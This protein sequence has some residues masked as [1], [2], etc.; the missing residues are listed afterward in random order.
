MPLTGGSSRAGARMPTACTALLARVHC[1]PV[2]RRTGNGKPTCSAPHAHLK[3]SPI[4]A[5]TPGRSRGD[6]R[7]S[8]LVYL[9]LD[10]S[11]M[12]PHT[13]H[14]VS[15]KT[16]QFNS[17]TWLI[18]LDREEPSGRSSVSSSRRIRPLPVLSQNNRR[19][20]CFS[21]RGSYDE[22]CNQK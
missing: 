14:A 17:T 2:D 21:I 9:K 3:L 7:D 5:S 13:R 18:T 4:S 10:R 15:A 16:S 11:A 6:A 1:W 20:G 8:S 22:E 19:R 12:T